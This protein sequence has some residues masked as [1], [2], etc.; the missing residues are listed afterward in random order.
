MVTVGMILHVILSYAIKALLLLLVGA[1][2]R[3]VYRYFMV[4]LVISTHKEEHNFSQEIE[5]Q[6]TRNRSEFL[7]Y[8]FRRS[9][10]FKDYFCSDLA[11]LSAYFCRLVLAN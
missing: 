6:V 3:T 8:A 4:L 2:G 7:H 9:I 10:C 5:F 1:L 11:A